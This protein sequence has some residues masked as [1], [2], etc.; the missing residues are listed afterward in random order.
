MKEKRLTMLK[1]TET[2]SDIF[3]PVC[4]KQLDKL[5]AVSFKAGPD[6]TKILTCF[7]SGCVDRTS[8]FVGFVGKDGKIVF[9]NDWIKL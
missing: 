3:C 2:K 1:N 7:N 4:Q 6:K 8:Q 5:E 9:F